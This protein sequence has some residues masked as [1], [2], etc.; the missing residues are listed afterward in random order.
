MYSTKSES[1]VFGHQTTQ[2]DFNSFLRF[3]QFEMEED[4]CDYCE[5]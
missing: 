1:I 3:I 2:S 4:D 5:T